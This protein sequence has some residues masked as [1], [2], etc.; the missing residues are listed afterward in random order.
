[1]TG[2]SALT[3]SI[4]PSEHADPGGESE[5]AAPGSGA[6]T[7]EQADQRVDDFPVEKSARRRFIERA[8]LSGLGVSILVHLVLLGIAV[9]VR[10]DYKFADAGGGGPEPVEFA[11]MAQSDLNEQTAV[12]VQEMEFAEIE[13][14][15]VLDMELLSEV[16]IDQSVSDLADAMAPDLQ[17][18]GM[19]IS[20]VDVRSG[21]S[22]AGSGEGASF[23]GLEASGK[24]FAYIVDRSGSMDSSLS[25]G[26]MTRWELTQIELIRSVHGLAA[27]A[28]FYVVLY[29][30]GP[31]P[32]MA[33]LDWMKANRMNKSAASVAV[34][35]QYPNGGTFPENAFEMVFRLDP[36]P[37]AIYFMTDGE[38]KEQVPGQIAKLNRK[39]RT[40]IH[41]IL[42]GES[43]NLQNFQKVEA[44]LKNIAR[45][46][47]G[48]YQHVVGGSQP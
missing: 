12:D 35:A 39:S 36:K 1:M 45:T 43:R 3:Y 6:Q 46:S 20:D 15:S 18:G 44:M 48:R 21:A 33:E 11:I 23:F 2:T 30:T 37:D 34:M 25:S 24:R 8:T 26:E 5:V 4:E 17:S 9:L 29:S 27:N 42:F 13:T 32:L 31:T 41:C 16:G 28:E 22:G 38:F 7:R 47:N 14:E 10:I 19:S 40:P